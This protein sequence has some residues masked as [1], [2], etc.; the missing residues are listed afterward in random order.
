MAPVD[1]LVGSIAA[2]A[3]T[4][5]SATLAMAVLEN[6]TRKAAAP[7]T[8]Q[9]NAAPPAGAPSRPP[10]GAELPDRGHDARLG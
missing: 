2:M 7:A 6:P 1:S 3:A 9:P 10:P 8:P 5:S 4:D